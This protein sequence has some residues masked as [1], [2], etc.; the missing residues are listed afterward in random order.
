MDSLVMHIDKKFLTPTG[1]FKFLQIVLHNNAFS[2]E[3]E[4][5]KQGLAMGSNPGP[6]IANVVVYKL[7]TK[8]LSID[9]PLMYNRFIDDIFLAVSHPID[10]IKFKETFGYLE[11][12]IIHE[13][14]N[15][16]SRLRNIV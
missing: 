8:W 1:L 10:L 11:L 3:N 13:K 16:V 4:F 12:N 9:K 7:E 14:K 5:F 2:F 6:A 15:S